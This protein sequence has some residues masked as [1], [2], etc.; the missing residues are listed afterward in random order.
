MVTYSVLNDEATLNDLN[1]SVNQQKGNDRFSV[2]VKA[3][4]S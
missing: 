1:C 3:W 2:E 4:I